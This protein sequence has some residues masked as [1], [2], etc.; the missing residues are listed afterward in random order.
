MIGL[1]HLNANTLYLS[2]EIYCSGY[3]YCAF[4][5]RLF[6]EQSDRVLLMESP[7]Q[8]LAERQMFYCVPLPGETAWAKEVSGCVLMHMVRDEVALFM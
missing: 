7:N 1:P 3:M 6:F 5:N 2:Q 4:V 8:V